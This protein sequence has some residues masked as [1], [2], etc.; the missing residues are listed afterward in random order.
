MALT[1]SRGP[2]HVHPG[3][4][5]QGQLSPTVAWVVLYDRGIQGEQEFQP[6]IVIVVL[7]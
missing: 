4:R 3:R 5:S 2:T 7:G 6:C 1:Y